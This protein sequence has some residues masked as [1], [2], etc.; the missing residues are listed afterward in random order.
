MSVTI[1]WALLNLAYLLYFASGLF[2]DILRLRVLWMTA[3]IF[4]LAH[5]IIDRLWP[6]VWWNIPVLLVHLWMIRGLV[7]E[8][9]QIDLDD[10]AE[11]IHQLMFS[12]LD[13]SQF[14]TLWHYGE[15]RTLTDEVLLTKGK[16][17]PDLTLLLEGE[18]AVHVSDQL[19]IR[20][21]PYRIVGEISTF[22]GEPASATVWASGTARFRSWA[23]TDLEVCS[24][25]HPL[26]HVSLLRAMGH[27]AARK[28]A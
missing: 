26:I 22:T 21:S 11:A 8:R 15:E 2:Q 18:F 6:A 16:D 5:G 9:R 13:R 3:T 19:S 25:K 17:V 14:N 7:T 20:L 24:L 10:E 23:K 12:D 4:F 28:I 27:E 1:G